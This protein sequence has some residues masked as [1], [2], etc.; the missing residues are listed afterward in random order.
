MARLITLISI[1]ILL[2]A[3]SAHATSTLVAA[4]DFEDQGTGNRT[5][6]VSG[7]TPL[8]TA[9]IDGPTIVDSGDED[10]GYV[11]QPAGNGILIGTNSKLQS[12]NSAMTIQLWV[13]K[14]NPGEQWKFTLGRDGGCR[15]FN[16]N[17]GILWEPSMSDSGWNP[18]NIWAPDFGNPQVWHHFLVTSNGTALRFYRDGAAFG[19]TV[20]R[21]GT[22]NNSTDYW[23]LMRAWSGAVDG[24]WNGGNICT[25]FL[26]DVAIWRGY[27]TAAV[28]AGLY[29][30][31]YTILNAPIYEYATISGTVTDGSDPIAGVT[32][33]LYSEDFEEIDSTT[34]DEDGEY[35]I[36][37]SAYG[38]YYVAA[39]PSETG[40]YYINELYNNTTSTADAD[41][42]DAETAT[43]ATGI[44]F[45]LAASGAIT[46]TVLDAGEDPIEDM[47]VIAA[48]ADD[49]DAMTAQAT[50][51]ED[52]EYTITGLPAGDYIVYCYDEDYPTIYYNN[53]DELDNATAVTIIGTATTANVDFTLTPFLVMTV[54]KCTVAKG[55][56]AG[57]D[58]ISLSGSFTDSLG[59]LNDVSEIDVSIV[60]TTDDYEVY[61][62]TLSFNADDISRNK[63]TYKHA[64]GAVTSLKLDM[65]RGTI[66]LAAK[67]VDLLGL[68]CPFGVR[69]GFGGHVLS[70]LVTEAIAN[71]RSPMPIKLLKGYDNDLR[72]DSAVATSTSLKVRGAIV[73]QK[74]GNGRHID[75][76][77]FSRGGTVAAWIKPT[78]NDEQWRYIFG[79]GGDGPRLFQM[80][81]EIKFG[82]TVDPGQW[83]L[84]NIT[85]DGADLEAG[86][87]YHIVGVYSYNSSDPNNSAMRLYVNGEELASIVEDPNC[88]NHAPK[89]VTC[90]F[91]IG[92]DVNGDSGGF[93]GRIDDAVIF[94]RALTEAQVTAL[95]NG[96]Y[97]GATSHWDFEDGTDS[98]TADDSGAVRRYIPTA[99]GELL[100]TTS[101]VQ[102]ADEDRNLVLSCD[103][104]PGNYVN[105]DIDAE[106]LCAN[107]ITITWGA[108]NFTLM[109]EK[110]YYRKG[111]FIHYSDTTGNIGATF[112]FNACTFI[113]SIRNT[114]ITLTSGT[115]E[116]GVS[117]DEFDESVDV[118]L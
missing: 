93:R 16:M 28:A 26:D 37:T 91:S 6:D 112:D 82:T 65:N 56:T 44:D 108:Q 59:D 113:L 96:I 114:P 35:F 38:S 52:G 86:N 27:A 107:N 22:I 11:A 81:S 50:T 95:M 12:F 58:S 92:N 32:I 117:F 34:T 1:T 76:F 78:G 83:G 7:V 24:S 61:S 97:T 80:G 106:D 85:S 40:L 99:D 45:A 102:D 8:L 33:V 115:A 84:T 103:G 2:F 41:L 47:V 105:C 89:A 72:V 79:P 43:P 5:A 88:S 60:S 77:D 118:G 15:I 98:T 116:F 71:G 23:S 49:E 29:N 100:G 10:R 3:V 46:G 111:N 21:T 51:D 13:K 57:S 75:K 104:D 90:A 31:T 39:L 69:I 4:W 55:Q 14:Q 18:L 74:G 109:A 67:N 54:T 62:E 53:V 63:Y 17:G 30:G 64:A 48:N 73:S 70:G 94:D 101:I 36:E 42:I 87:W 66:S 25:D 19:D 20:A 9:T 68:R 110:T